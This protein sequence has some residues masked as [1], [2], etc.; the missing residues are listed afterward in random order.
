MQLKMNQIQAWFDYDDYDDGYDD[1][2][3]ED[4]D[5]DVVDEKDGDDNDRCSWVG[6]TVSRKVFC[7]KIPL[8]KA[9]PVY[10]Q[11]SYYN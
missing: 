5:G 6:V 7:W 11:A 10:Q 8:Q 4:E 3:D 1:D 2:Y 9:Y